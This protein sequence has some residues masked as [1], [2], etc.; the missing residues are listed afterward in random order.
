MPCLVRTS[1]RLV[2]QPFLEIVSPQGGLV[3]ADYCML[4]SFTILEFSFTHTN[5]TFIQGRVVLNVP[6]GEFS[7]LIDTPVVF[8]KKNPNFFKPDS[9]LFRQSF[10]QLENNSFAFFVTCQE[11]DVVSFCAARTVKAIH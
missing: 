10:G 6:T 3:E 8:W 11:I 1:R 4:G 5:L 9:F 7:C 2:G